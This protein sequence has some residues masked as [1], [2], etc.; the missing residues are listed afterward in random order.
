MEAIAS[1]KESSAA[2]IASAVGKKKRIEMLDKANE[3][4]VYVLN[5]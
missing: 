2:R 4:G 3:L 1:R 5:R